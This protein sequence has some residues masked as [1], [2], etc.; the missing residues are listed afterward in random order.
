MSNEL[1]RSLTSPP[2][3]PTRSPKNAPVTHSTRFRRKFHLRTVLVVP[4]I[5]PIV[6]STGLVGWL[7]FRN[8][9]RSI[10]DLA[11]QLQSETSS[12]VQQYLDSYLKTPNQINQINLAAWQMGLLNLQDFQNTGKYFWQQMQVFNVGYINFGNTKGE[13]IGVERLDN[14]QLIIDEVSERFKPGKMRSF[15]TN[16]QGDRTKLT[17]VTDYDPR[18]EAWYTESVKAGKPVWSSIYQWEDK[19]DILSVSSSYPVRDRNNQIIGVLGV[20]LILTQVSNFLGQLKIGQSGKVFIL[21]RNGFLVANS[22]NSKPFQLVE[23]KASRLKGSQSNEL[24][25]QA[26]SQYLTRF[27]DLNR[28]KDQQF[29][30]DIGNQR[31]LVKVTPWKD[32]FGL[33]WLIVV[34]VPEA[35]FMGQINANARTTILLCLITFA[36]ATA[37]GVLTAR[38]ISGQIFQ[39][40]QAS[41]AIAKGNLNQNVQVNGISEIEDLAGSF[42]SMAGQIKDSFETLEEKEKWFRTLV[43]N[44]PGAIY[45]SQYDADWTIEFISDSIAD[46]SGYP[47]AE[48]VHNQART[49]ASIVNP[50]DRDLVDDMV[51]QAVAARQPYILE[52]RLL[53]QDGSI[54]WVVERGRATLNQ[55]GKPLY[56]DGAIFDITDRKHAE[57]ALQES[58]EQLNQQNVALI[59]LTRN[60]AL[61]RGDWQT[62]IQEITT[63][64]TRTLDVERAS[65]WLYGK[66]KAS[67]NCVDLFELTANR[68]SQGT[69]L[70]AADYLAYFRALE[71]DQIIAAHNAYMDPRTAE[72][73]DSYLKPLGITTMLDAPIRLGGETIGVLC[74]ERVA[75]PRPWTV[76]E[77]GFIRSVADLI[78]IAIEAHQ[79]KQAEATMEQQLAAIEATINGIAILNKEGRLIYMNTAHAKIYG[80]DSAA[81]LIGQPWQILYDSEEL[82]RFEQEIMPRFFQEGYW[83]GEAIGKRRDGTTYQQEVSLTLTKD[84]GLVCVVQDIT[85]RKRAEEALRIAEENYRGIYENALEGIFQSGLDG[86]Y[87]S[88]NP[89]M[90]RLY[91]YIS[92]NEMIASVTQIATQ[93]Y[94]NPDHQNEFKRLMEE[95]GEVK[96]LEYQVYRQD[97]SVIWIQENTRAVRGSSERLLYYEGIVQDITQRKR[98]EEELKQQLQELQIEIDQQKREREVAQITQSDY[99]Q[100]L[101]A[102]AE[103]LHSD[104][105]W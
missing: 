90:A 36:V 98:L 50:S 102:E 27:G 52:Y 69:E 4:F 55:D 41:Q 101:Q 6:V 103:S 83:S 66:E 74:L 9:Q 13:F 91:G 58:K 11:I 18:S 19:E 10:D 77:Q 22:G 37:I 25:I 54:R 84:G 92:P 53:H 16:N 100:E 93:T 68:H 7:S 46:I 34:V 43:A 96:N 87:I 72:L 105:D 70:M 8:A 1:G 75:T 15:A 24:A 63:V 57:S 95:Q 45:R 33:D 76:E 82:Q 12:R 88:V 23:G 59:E 31:Q 38:W 62:A 60:K 71:E 28:T 79:R 67:I 42:N 39:L 3:P 44:I 5:I 14:G 81:E 32:Q 47:A 78:T 51:N 21:E 20:D 85:D 29:S 2:Q 35:D 17:E 89:A 86:R 73:S 97:G 94:V 49:F 65:V 48:F 61:S 99:F 80:Y 30:F 40:N 26:T 56:L 104:D 64:A